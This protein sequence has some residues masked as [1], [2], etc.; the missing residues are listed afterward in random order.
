MHISS[1]SIEGFRTYDHAELACELG[2]TCL[3]G[4]NGAGKTN[5][6]EALH[7][8]CTARSALQAEDTVLLR[9]GAS[10]FLLQARLHSAV[11]DENPRKLL[12]SY[13]PGERKRL[14][15]NGQSCA[16]R[17][18]YASHALV[19]MI[20]PADQ[21]LLQGRAQLRRDFMDALLLRINATYRKQW[22]DYKSYL[23]ARNAALKAPLVGKKV[24]KTLLFS[25]DEQMLPL[26]KQIS[27]QRIAFLEE[28]MVLFQQKYSALAGHDEPATITYRSD[29]LH[30][31]FYENYRKML[32]EDICLM[33]THIG[34]HRDDYYFQLFG[35]PL[36][37]H[38]SQGQFKTFLYALKLTHADFLYGIS[39]Q[40]P[41]LL[42]DDM[43]D[44]LDPLRTA[45]LFQLLLRPRGREIAF[46]PSEVQIFITAPEPPAK[47]FL[48]PGIEEIQ[49]VQVVNGK[50]RY[51]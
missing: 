6:L 10:H 27:I 23:Q 14:Q 25:Y 3:H 40:M 44:K 34:V 24:D 29:A 20:S 22:L 32:P 48:P 36:R 18:D 21:A 1:L 7:Y 47:K 28:Y 37:S 43:L 2:V 5:F 49:H 9:A 15:I 30:A 26:A 17:S 16:R 35:Y 38:G 50:L 41:I 13:Q 31:D 46:L 33:R 51:V 45:R 39:K 42:F 8:V 4:A 11:T 19:L 12:V